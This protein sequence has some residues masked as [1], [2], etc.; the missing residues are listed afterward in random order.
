MLDIKIVPEGFKEALKAL[1][2]VKMG[3]PKAA[4]DAIN[5]GL[6][7]GQTAAAKG[8]AARYTITSTAVK[9]NITLKKASWTNLEGHLNISGA[10]L[11][12]GTFKISVGHVKLSRGP[13]RQVISATIRKGAKVLV[14][15]A[16]QLPSGRIMERRQPDKFPIWPVST[17]SVAH[18]AGQ[19]EVGQAIQDRLQEVTKTRLDHNVKFA[20]TGKEE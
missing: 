2:N 14:K 13:R 4:G 7:A 11:P 10:M 3:F 16:F 12:L 19:K 15:G 1:E 17:I 18:M 5:R 8:I 9:D 6:L 20:L